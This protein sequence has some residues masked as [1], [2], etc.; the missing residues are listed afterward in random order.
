MEG[1]NFCRDG[2][3]GE[4]TMP[5][6]SSTFASFRAP[7]TRRRK[8]ATKQL[9]RGG[10]TNINFKL[11]ISGS[12]RLFEYHYHRYPMNAGTTLFTLALAIH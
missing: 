12:M 5:F 3:N 6:L 10:R 11:P 8:A 2:E 9:R 1:W 4:N 7:S